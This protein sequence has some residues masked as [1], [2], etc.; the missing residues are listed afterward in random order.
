MFGGAGDTLT[1]D[2]R[3]VSRKQHCV[4][5]L[6]CLK[7]ASVRA[8]YIVIVSL[9]LIIGWTGVEDV[10]DEHINFRVFASSGTIERDLLLMAVGF[11]ILVAGDALSKRRI[12]AARRPGV[13]VRTKTRG[14]VRYF[15]E[16]RLW[17][18][19]FVETAVEAADEIGSIIMWTGAWGFIEIA[20]REVTRGSWL[21]KLGI[22]VLAF[23]VYFALYMLIETEPAPQPVI[24]DP[25]FQMDELL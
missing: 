19:A 25:Y 3:P 5:A 4:N 15:L 2:P 18:A 24:L 22:A 1:S 12:H 7:R 17:K 10:L 20:F 14:R 21:G 16:G 13:S 8:G 6:R 9:I 23:L 11:A